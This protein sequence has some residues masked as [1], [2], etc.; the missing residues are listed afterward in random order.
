MGHTLKN[1]HERSRLNILQQSMFLFFSTDFGTACKDL[2]DIKKSKKMLKL[3]SASFTNQMMKQPVLYTPSCASLRMLKYIVIA[4]TAK[5]RNLICSIK[6]LDMLS[7]PM[8][9]FT[10][11]RIVG[12]C[13]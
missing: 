2:F 6:S 13:Y 5:S 11:D 4:H 3:L 10:A 12:R 7:Y 8:I 1:T 9:D